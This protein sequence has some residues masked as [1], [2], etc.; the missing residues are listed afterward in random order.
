MQSLYEL[1]Y[2]WPVCSMVTK[3]RDKNGRREFETKERKELMSL[4]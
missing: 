2:E 3:G 1:Q 4:E